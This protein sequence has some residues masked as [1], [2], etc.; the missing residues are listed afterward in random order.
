MSALGEG[1]I[2]GETGT[3]T[4]LQHMPD[5]IPDNPAT[6]SA[7][8]SIETLS[9]IL[10][11]NWV[12][13]NT[14]VIDAA[15]QPGHVFGTIKIHPKNCNDYITHI[16]QMFLT[17]NGSFKVRSRFMATYQFGGSFRLGF[18]PPRFT[19]AEVQN[20]PI[21]TLTAYPN[22]DL[23]PK[24]TMWSEF[25]AS[26]ERNV[27]FHWMS[28]LEDE[29]PEAFAGWFV[30]YV[31]APLV[32]SGTSTSV[33]MLI[34]AAG[35]FEFAQLAPISKIAPPTSGWLADTGSNLLMQMG[36]D[37]MYA[38]YSNYLLVL[39]IP[40]KSIPAGFTL[41]NQVGGGVPSATGSVFYS[42]RLA[43]RDKILAGEH[44]SVI[45]VGDAII[46]NNTDAHFQ[47]QQGL[48]RDFYLTNTDWR[49]KI[50]A[51]EYVHETAASMTSFASQAYG[52]RWVDSETNPTIIIH[53]APESSATSGR[54]PG[55]VT[56]SDRTQYAFD[57]TKYTIE[58]DNST[59]PNT[60][61]DESIV[62]FANAYH[63]TIN[64][65]TALMAKHF[66]QLPKPDSNNSQ[67]YQLFSSTQPQPIMT[68]R[69][70]PNGMWT[71]NATDVQIKLPNDGNTL[72]LRYLQD[73]P[74]NTPLPTNM[75]QARFARY[76]ARATSK[77]YS[78]S[79]RRIHMWRAPL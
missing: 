2:P 40:I 48:D 25:Q 56:S 59:L 62:L 58:G 60:L 18:L 21:Q 70:H 65:H 74:M 55:I 49:N 52:M 45:A 77:N 12:W 51:A 32:L 28:D 79:Q 30:F 27:L 37:D 22:I 1:M 44:V 71:T 4:K 57:I 8:T 61:P 35:A 73:L 78:P 14:F 11:Q 39:P 19:Q 46:D 36:C 23:D 16:S 20:L 9:N 76:A 31:A 47:P 34:E 17:W 68:W 41:A 63:A 64:L 33:S 7:N 67:L 15:M 42:K 69:L 29:K 50:F 6:L 72:Y 53:K 54:C 26:D 66:A 10:Y 43:Y 24:N 38:D 75:S 3:V 5:Q 13:R